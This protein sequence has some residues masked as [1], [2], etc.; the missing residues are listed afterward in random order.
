MTIQQGVVA[1]KVKATSS[2]ETE[3]MRLLLDRSAEKEPVPTVE[4]GKRRV[5]EPTGD[6]EEIAVDLAEANTGQLSKGGVNQTCWNCCVNILIADC[7]VL[8]PRWCQRVTGL[9]FDCP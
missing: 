7:S 2:S 1:A 5:E 4:V 3:R 9:S 8:T 6:L